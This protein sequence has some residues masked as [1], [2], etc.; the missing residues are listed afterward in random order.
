MGDESTDFKAC[1]PLPHQGIVTHRFPKGYPSEGEPD[2]RYSGS[3]EK[4]SVLFYNAAVS[5]WEIN[6]RGGMEGK[7][8]SEVATRAATCE[9]KR[10]HGF[11]PATGEGGHIVPSS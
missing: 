1:I 6:K 11:Q 8:H 3:A 9:T 10:R 7:G 2:S 5:P 4:N